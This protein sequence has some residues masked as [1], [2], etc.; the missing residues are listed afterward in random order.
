[1][2]DMPQSTQAPLDSYALNLAECQ[3]GCFVKVIVD[4]H[5]CQGHARCVTICP[6]VFDIDDQG[7]GIVIQ[8]EVPADLIDDVDEAVLACPESAI[9]V[10][11]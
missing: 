7:N 9:R 4:S 10:E 6:D 1:M 2:M 8:D 11:R 5:L 3:E